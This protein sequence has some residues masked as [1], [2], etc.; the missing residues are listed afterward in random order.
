MTDH[1]IWV[2]KYRPTKV[3]DCILPFKIKKIFMEYVN[4]GYI[5]DNLILAGPSGL[6]KTTVALALM[7]DLDCEYMLL[8]ASLKGNIDTL[9]YEV[10]SF[11][12]KSSLDG[13]RKYVIFD[14]GDG[15]TR[16]GQDAFRGLIE[17]FSATCGFIITCNNKNAINKAIRSRLS[18]ID[19]KI[20]AKEKSMLMKSFYKRIVEIL[21]LEN[22]EY[23]S[24]AIID[25]MARNKNS[26]DFR[27]IIV[28]LQKTAKLGVINEENLQ[29]QIETSFDELVTYLKNKDFNKMRKWVSDHQDYNTDEFY[30]YFYDNMHKFLTSASVP[31]I[32]IAIAKYQYQAAF[33]ADQ[34]INNAAFLTEVMVDATYK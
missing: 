13:K 27:N 8:N 2:E 6:G 12:S 20:N 22:V 9:R 17:E 14:E 25:Y 33:V 7:N 21:E 30:R 28:T 23:D 29:N 10:Q 19:F 5:S 34:E 26:L 3:E 4:I 11:A 1:V 15:I 31:L 16:Q 18:V 24:K 32:L